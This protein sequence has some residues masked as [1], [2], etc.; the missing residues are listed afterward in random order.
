VA[1]CALLLVAAALLRAPAP[2]VAEELR[3]ELSGFAGWTSSDGVN[4]PAAY[5]PGAGTF[6]GIEA[7]DSFS[8][9]LSAAF[10]VSETVSL[11]FL[12]G[13]QESQLSVFG[14]A[15]LVVG[16][17]AVENYHGVIAYH[18]R[19][20]AARVRPFVLGGLGATRYGQL[21]FSAADQPRDIGGDTRFST[22]WGGGVKLWP[23]RSVGI[24]LQGRWTP[25]YIKSKSA[26]WWCDPYWG[27]YVLSEAQYA[28]QFELAA[29]VSLRF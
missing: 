18:F 27:C 8:W 16:D 13:R 6:T 1:R 19:P 3:V 25:T 24:R 12:F 21:T 28:N 4:G 26:G 17:M 20:R 7:G 14:T 2:A 15:T 29:G 5:V 9:G 11:G 10:H 23:G 22:T